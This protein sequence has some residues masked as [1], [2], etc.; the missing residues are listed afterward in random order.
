MENMK[1]TMIKFHVFILSL[2]LPG[3]ERVKRAKKT[4]ESA[5]VA[6]PES[7]YKRECPNF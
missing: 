5:I 2:S 6:A 7:Y 3:I 1:N 4:P